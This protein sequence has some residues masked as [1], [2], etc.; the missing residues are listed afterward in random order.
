MTIESEM[1]PLSL[2]MINHVNSV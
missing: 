2:E 1:K